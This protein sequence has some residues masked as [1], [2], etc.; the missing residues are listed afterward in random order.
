[1]EGPVPKHERRRT[2]RTHLK[3]IV[4]YQVHAPVTVRFTSG[5]QDINAIA[6]DIAEQGMAILTNY[7]IPLGTEVKLQFILVNEPPCDIKGPALKEIM[8][9][10]IVR[11]S[12]HTPEKAFR[13]GIEF[14][15]VS[16]ENQQFLSYFVSCRNSNP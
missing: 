12:Q 8:L 4:R 2:K 10:G 14:Q 7:D 1:M 3:L 16:P 13:A 11:Y 6:V 9:L 5:H 15:Q